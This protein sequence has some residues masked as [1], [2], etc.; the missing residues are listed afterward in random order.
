L[1]PTFYALVYARCYHGR[2]SHN[3]YLP[4]LYINVCY[5]C[6][7]VNAECALITEGKWK[8]RIKMRR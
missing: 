4:L 1:V 2:V 8:R 5:L 6:R 3:L 7:Y